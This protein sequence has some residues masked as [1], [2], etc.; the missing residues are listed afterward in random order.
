M[1]RLIQ[2]L[3]PTC[4]KPFMWKFIATAHDV[5]GVVESV[6]GQVKSLVHKKVMSL[7]KNQSI[8]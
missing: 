5:K 2:R 3:F 8:V 1:R 6:G 7:G 4:K